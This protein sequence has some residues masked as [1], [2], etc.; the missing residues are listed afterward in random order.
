VR[1]YQEYCVQFWAT[2]YK[3]DLDI[4]QIRAVQMTK[5]LEYL[6][7]AERTWTVQ[8]GGGSGVM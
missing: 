5:G 8:P 1:P 4:L 7:E 2:Q 3:R 6:S